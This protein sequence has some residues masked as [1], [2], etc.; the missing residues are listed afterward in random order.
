MGIV[1]ERKGRPR[2]PESMSGNGKEGEKDGRGRGRQQGG[3]HSKFT[4]PTILQR[5]FLTQG[6]PGAASCCPSS[7]LSLMNVT[8]HAYKQCLCLCWRFYS[9]EASQHL[10]L[11]PPTSSHAC[12][13]VSNTS[14][15][16]LLYKYQKFIQECPW[17]SSG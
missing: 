11:A 7:V 17:W 12:I 5:S 2:Y 8:L 3:G 6:T 10:L 1:K 4:C 14:K 13:C 16:I 15:Y 9:L